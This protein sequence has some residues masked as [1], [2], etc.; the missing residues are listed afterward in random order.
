[1]P[2]TVA[3]PQRWQ[4][5]GYG[6]QPLYTVAATMPGDSATRSIGLRTVALD[7]TGGA[8]ALSVNGVPI[9]AKGAN[10]IP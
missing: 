2:L 10:L 1:I 6:A 5:V 3:Q 4:P 8:F 7:R 9:F